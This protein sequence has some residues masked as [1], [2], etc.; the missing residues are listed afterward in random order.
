MGVDVFD[1][2]IEAECLLA[3]PLGALV[4]VA[5]IAE[6]DRRVAQPRLGMVDIPLGPSQTHMLL[7]AEGPV[8]E[9]ER[10]VDLLVEQIRG[11][12]LGHQCLLRRLISVSRASSRFAQKPR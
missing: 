5:W 10:G 12:R 7:E 1:E 2:D 9:L 8:Q 11:N 6:V 4:V 3:E